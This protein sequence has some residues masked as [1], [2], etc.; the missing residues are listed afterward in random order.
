MI[1]LRTI[2]WYEVKRTV[3][4][5]SFWIRT[6]A[7]PLLIAAVLTLSVFSS[8]TSEQSAKDLEQSRFSAA[9]LD[10]S[11]IVMS[12]LLAG[13]NLK[14]VTD[15]SAAIADVRAGRMEAFVYIPAQP[16]TQTVEIYAADAGL[17]ENAKYEAL[18]QN[19]IKTSLSAKLGGNDQAQL[20]A[21]GPKTQ[22]TT[23]QN[24]QAVDVM[25]RSI[26]PALYLVLFYI[27]IVL[28]GNQ[29]L[30]TTTEEKENRV[31]EML[32]TSVSARTLI[33]GKLWALATMGALQIAAILAPVV[34][35][36]VGFRDQL[37][38][39]SLQ[40]SSLQFE[41]AAML[42]G[43]A[44]FI[45]ACVLFSALLVAIG[46]AVPTAKEAN[47]YFGG[48][49]IAMFLPFYAIAAIA[50]NPGLPIVQVMSYFPLT[51]PITLMVRNAVGNAAPWELGLGLLITA[52]TAAAV[53]ALAVRIFRFG[54]LEYSRKLSLREM[55][56]RTQA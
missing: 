19:L 20:L 26:P 12:D 56:G 4:K 9:V 17:V 36:Y 50:T 55:F 44:L 22:L 33:I 34:V 38:L 52:A 25:S 47:G 39:P 49:I 24:G 1:N 8:R 23:Y 37:S 41:P 46:S 14:T 11:G 2:W 7:I 6:L 10:E 32:L 43:A 42:F 45:T 27:V 29:M 13:L 5:P 18:A 35:A 3:T 31:V 54:S 53:M 51:A 28:L 48:V 40:L 15:R 21:N 30:T 16:Q